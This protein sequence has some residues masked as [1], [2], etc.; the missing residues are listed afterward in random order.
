MNDVD[1]TVIAVM[2]PRFRYGDNDI[3]VP[4]SLGLALLLNYPRLRF[5]GAFR[6]AFFAPYLVG[7]VFVSVIFVLL[8]TP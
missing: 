4:L 7:N 6:F 8:P 3:W 2:P 5:R 1:Y